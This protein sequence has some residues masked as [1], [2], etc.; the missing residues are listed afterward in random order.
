MISVEQSRDAV[1]RRL[2]LKQCILLQVVKKTA[3]M[4]E[5]KNKKKLRDGAPTTAHLQSPLHHSQ[6]LHSP[7][8]KLAHATQHQ[9]GC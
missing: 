9:S 7:S 3:R 4:K 5:K 2:N 1:T 8:Q 6:T